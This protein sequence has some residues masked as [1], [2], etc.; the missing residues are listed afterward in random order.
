[1]SG[2]QTVILRG[3]TQRELAARLIQAAPPNAVV[4]IRP[5]TRS[6]EQNSKFHAMISDIARAK[7]QG[8]NLPVDVW[9]VLILAACG[10]K[11]RFE[12]A[13]DGN[14][15]VPIGLRSSR[16]TKGEMS[17]AIEYMYSYG[18]EN[19]IVW[20]DLPGDVR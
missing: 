16:L 19:L 4:N 12:P 13:L 17:D 14:G 10:H 18:A 7:P 8:R 1:M 6:L 11:V 20:S 2:G 9:K 3:P 15:V 5:E